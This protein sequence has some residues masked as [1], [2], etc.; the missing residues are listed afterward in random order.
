MSDLKSEPLCELHYNNKCLLLL[1]LVFPTLSSL[2]FP[3]EIFLVTYAIEI[4]INKWD[5]RWNESNEGVHSL[6]CA[7]QE[8][9]SWR[10]FRIVVGEY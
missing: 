2:E 4:S 8:E 5:A 6:G 1:L 3:V 9:K 7:G 10:K